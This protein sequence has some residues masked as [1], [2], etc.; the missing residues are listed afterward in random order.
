MRLPRVRVTPEGIG[1]G[2]EKGGRVRTGSAIVPGA[3]L[4]AGAG[5]FVGAFL[6]C[7]IFQAGNLCG[8]FGVFVTGPLGAVGG[9]IAGWLWSRRDRNA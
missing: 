7:S 6:A 3:L 8:L 2:D 5:Y 4:G 9:G 1:S